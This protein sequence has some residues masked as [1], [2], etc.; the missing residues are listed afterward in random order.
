MYFEDLPYRN[1][2]L[3]DAIKNFDKNIIKHKIQRETSR[4][5]M[6]LARKFGKTAIMLLAMRSKWTLV[7]NWATGRNLE[8]LLSPCLKVQFLS[9][10]MIVC[11]DMSED[12]D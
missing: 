3:A 9:M 6:N 10:G 4:H 1:I 11:F 7:G 2:T 8:S 12:P 5:H